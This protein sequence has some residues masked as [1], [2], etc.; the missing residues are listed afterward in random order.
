MNRPFA[1]LTQHPAAAKDCAPVR[2]YRQPAVDICK[3]FVFCG[4]TL[5]VLLGG[6]INET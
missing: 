6:D 4:N 5:F 2:V 3:F 1:W